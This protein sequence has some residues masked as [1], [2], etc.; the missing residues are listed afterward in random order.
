M[1]EP[2]YF[3]GVFETF[4]ILETE[5]LVLRELEAADVQAVF[6]IFSDDEVTRYY[7]FETF[8]DTQQ[9]VTLIERQKERFRRKTG[10]RWGITFK[11]ED[12][13]IG[14]VGLMLPAEKR[15]GGLGYDLARPYWRRGIMSEVLREVIRFGFET[16]GLNRLQALVIPGNVASIRLLEKLGFQDQGVLK[17]HAFFKGRYQDLHNFILARGRSHELTQIDTN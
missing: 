10:I 13:V 17:N 8:T 6:R 12:V 9:A 7:D 16:A 4:P 11:G 1:S 14:T 3:E 15:K 5:R 2:A